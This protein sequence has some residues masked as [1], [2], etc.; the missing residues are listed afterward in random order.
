MG[1]FSNLEKMD[2]G[3]KGFSAPH[4]FCTGY[5]CPNHAHVC[6]LG[7][8]SNMACPF[9]DINETTKQLIWYVVQEYVEYRRRDRG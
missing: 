4:S 6:D 2:E 9:L 5:S 1:Y 7:R 3:G 8:L